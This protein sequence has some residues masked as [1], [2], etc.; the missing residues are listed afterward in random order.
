VELLVLG[1]ACGDPLTVAGYKREAEPLDEACR[2]T[3]PSIG[4][5][6]GGTFL[7]GRTEDGSA[8]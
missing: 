3:P 7:R 4:T 1:G 8:I 6:F 2:E 5:E